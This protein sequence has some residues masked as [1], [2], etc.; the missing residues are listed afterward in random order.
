[1]TQLRDLDRSDPRLFRKRS[2]G[3]LEIFDV[4]IER[5]VDMRERRIRRI[6]GFLREHWMLNMLVPPHLCESLIGVDFLELR[7]CEGHAL[8]NLSLMMIEHAAP[9]WMPLSIA[10]PAQVAAL[11][12]ACKDRRDGSPAVWIEQPY[13]D[14]PFGRLLRRFE[15]P[16]LTLR[17]ECHQWQNSD[18]FAGINLQTTDLALSVEMDN[19]HTER[20]SRVF[21]SASDFNDWIQASARCYMAGADGNC[22]IIDVCH[23]AGQPFTQMGQWRAGLQTS[24]GH[25]QSESI[26]RSGEQMLAWECRGYCDREGQLLY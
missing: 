25:W 12:V 22:A 13:T 23:D 18:G 26:F 4:R 20:Q 17:L 3:G 10:P 8:L 7:R 5:Y 24:L 15:F 21:A 9:D 14:S 2:D 6:E 1:M 11:R 19:Q 16:A